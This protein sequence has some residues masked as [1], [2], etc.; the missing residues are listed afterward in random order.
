M[1]KLLVLTA[2]SAALSIGAAWAQSPAPQAKTFT[3]AVVSSPEQHATLYFDSEWKVVDK[4]VDGGYFRKVLG[5][6]ANGYYVVQD[7][8]Q[9]SGTKQTEAFE[10]MTQDGLRSGESVENVH[11]AL[12]WYTQ[13]GVLDQALQ[14]AHGV[15]TYGEKYHP[16]GRVGATVVPVEHNKYRHKIQ[17]W[18]EDGSKEDTYVLKSDGVP[19]LEVWEAEGR[20]RIRAEMGGQDINDWVVEYWNEQGQ[21]ATPHALR[22]LL[23]FVVD[24]LKTRMP[25]GF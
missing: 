12:T 19:T 4:P 3:A 17:L 25:G 22:V 24:T 21:K 11:G 6:S 13:E 8:Y 5:K 18:A 1:K 20:Q 16:N 15:F 7:L 14:F 2:L 9:D 10:V 23:E